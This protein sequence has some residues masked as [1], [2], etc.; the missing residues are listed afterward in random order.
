MYV[1]VLRY[2]FVNSVASRRELEMLVFRWNH[3]HGMAQRS[4][5]RCASAAPI[6]SSPPLT[7]R[8]DDDA[9][10]GHVTGNGRLRSSSQGVHQTPFTAVVSGALAK[11]LRV[12]IL[13]QRMLVPYLLLAVLNLIGLSLIAPFH[14][15]A[16]SAVVRQ[17]PPCAKGVGCAAAPPLTRARVENSGRSRPPPPPSAK[18]WRS[19]SGW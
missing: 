2:L 8:D 18:A 1:F 15:W 17:K 6:P 5:A 16:E 12:A 4:P 3:I 13:W 10:G 14:M 7:G 11:K 19:S 9:R